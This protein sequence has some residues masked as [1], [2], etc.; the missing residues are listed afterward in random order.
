[1]KKRLL[2]TLMISAFAA[3]WGVADTPPSEDLNVTNGGLESLRGSAE[4]N[5]ERSAEMLKQIPKDR[6][7]IDR[8]YVHQP[9]LIPHDIRGY[10]V[11][12][13]SNKCLSCHGWKFAGEVG[14]TKIS[15]THFETREGITLSDVSPRRYFCLQCHVP[16][17]DAKPLVANEF[18]PVEALKSTN[19]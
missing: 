9:P 14:A 7:L 11:D 17:A 19:Q 6:S 1:M 4:L 3:G 13:N 15:P 2:I 18:V 5:E 10:R 8:N 12:I 16:Q